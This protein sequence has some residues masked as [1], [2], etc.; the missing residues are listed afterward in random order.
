[1]DIPVKQR[2]TCPARHEFFLAPQAIFDF[3]R[4]FCFTETNPMRSQCY[5]KIFAY[6][7]HKLWPFIVGK[8]ASPNSELLWVTHTKK[9]ER[10]AI[11]RS[12]GKAKYHSRSQAPLE[13]LRVSAS[14]FISKGVGG[15]VGRSHTGEFYGFYHS[16]SPLFHHHFGRMDFLLLFS[17]HLNFRKPMKQQSGKAIILVAPTVPTVPTW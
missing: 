3:L 2:N 5:W 9:H 1:M 16:K 10:C 11:S 12:L 8:D 7:S 14:I 6:I 17:N 4:F 15:S 13:G